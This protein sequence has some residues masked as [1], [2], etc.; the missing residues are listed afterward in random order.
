[1]GLRRVDLGVAELTNR[2]GGGYWDDVDEKVGLPFSR[3]TARWLTPLTP[4]L[5]PKVN[6]ADRVMPD[7]ALVDWALEKLRRDRPAARA[8]GAPAERDGGAAAPAPELAR[9][10]SS[11]SDS[12]ARI[13]S[14]APFAYCRTWWPPST[15]S[16]IPVTYS[17]PS[18]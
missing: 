1:M 2:F 4:T 12:G 5:N 9:S 15:S 17:A 11:S 6:F 14:V 7:E 16:T 10:C 8:V 3:T 18:R 13:G